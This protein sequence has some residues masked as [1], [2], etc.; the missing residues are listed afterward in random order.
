MRKSVSA[1]A[2]GFFFLGSGV[3]LAG[4]DGDPRQ[5][6]QVDRICFGRDINNFKTIKG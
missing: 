1:F 5:G 3:A 4:D 6:E 2:A